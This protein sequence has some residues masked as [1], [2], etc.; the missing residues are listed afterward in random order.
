MVET[1]LQSF[2]SRV[3]IVVCFENQYFRIKFFETGNHNNCNSKTFHLGLIQNCNKRHYSQNCKLANNLKTL[4]V[5][6][7]Y[8]FRNVVISFSNYRFLPYIKR[9]EILNGVWQLFLFIITGIKTLLAE[10][11]LLKAFC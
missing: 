8:G 9:E 7:C 3:P 4:L 2:F 5:K 10:L 6:S 1:F 11:F